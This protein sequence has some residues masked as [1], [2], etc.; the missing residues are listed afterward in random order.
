M[1]SKIVF[2]RFLYIGARAFHLHTV[3]VQSVTEQ[4]LV[5]L[6]S[7]PCLKNILLLWKEPCLRHSSQL[8]SQLIWTLPTLQRNFFFNTIP[9]LKYFKA[10]M[11]ISTLSRHSSVFDHIT[12]K[13]SL[14]PNK[15]HEIKTPQQHILKKRS[16]NNALFLDADML[17]V[18]QV[19]KLN[20]TVC[21]GSHTSVISSFQS[22]SKEHRVSV[23]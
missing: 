13:Y 11:D 6:N 5:N 2:H 16:S 15:K 22:L 20:L 23:C 4:Q 14:K 3:Y 7:N 17:Q 21:A 8:T 12:A 1:S 9:V 19:A 10:Q 18:L